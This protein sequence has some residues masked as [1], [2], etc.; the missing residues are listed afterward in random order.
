MIKPETRAIMK[1][2]LEGFIQSVTN[3]H[4]NPNLKPSESRPTLSYSKEGKIKPFHE[5]LLPEGV[6]R[7][8]EFE[9]SFS[10]K[11]GTTFEEC[12]RLI[13]SDKYKDA[14]RGLR[15]SGTVSQAA[16]QTIETTVNAIGSGGANA[17]YLDIVHN[18]VTAA[19]GGGEPRQRIADLYLLDVQGNEIFFEIKSPKP[20]KG[21]C[22]EAADRLLQIHA[23]RGK[24]APAVRT[25]YAMAY[26]PYGEEKSS[27]K[28]SFA[29]R[30]MDVDN[31][32]LIGAE[33]W[34]LVGG[35]GT[36]EEILEL[37]REVGREKG[38]DMLDQLALDY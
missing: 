8:N 24:G 4:R 10:T 14:Q 25:Y 7:I 23:I 20:N 1:G 9:R 11:M 29:V 26:N 2:Y 31:Q 15:I 22:L 3:Q 36:Y 30:Y 19:P 18:V 6:L 38:P 37:Y 17:N 5:A 35:P 32:V 33:F 27:Y 16:I 13:G 12:A 28:H 34:N 21:Q